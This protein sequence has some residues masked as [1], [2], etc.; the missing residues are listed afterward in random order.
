LSPDI[1]A[2]PLA[3][4]D[5]GTMD[6]LPALRAEGSAAPARWGRLG[7]TLLLLGLVVWQ[8]CMTLGLFGEERPWERVLDDEPV[9]SGRHPLHLYHGY[10]GAWSL[11]HTGSACCYDPAFQAGYP[12]TPVFDSGS[13]PAEF[14]LALA[15]GT[16]NPAAYKI[17]LAVCCMLVPV[18]LIVA[19]RG[20]GLGLAGTFLATAMGLL[21][22]WGGPGRKAL[23]AGDVDL[24][25][26]AL[27]ALAHA[28]LLLQFCRAASVDCWVGLL[29]TGCL[30]WYSHPLLYFVLSPLFLVYYVTV[31]TRH[32]HLPWHVALLATQA[33][34]LAINSFW[35]V[36]WVTYWWIRSPLR[37][38]PVTLQHRTL[39]T[40]WDAPVWGGPAD[41]ALAVVIL[42]SALLG[43]VLFH[44]GRQRAAARV[45]G[46]GAWG[47]WLLAVLGV[48]WE[49][50]GRVGTHGL[51]VPALWF[52]AVPAAHAWVQVYRALGY[53][54]GS[55]LRA[56]VLAA[57]LLAGLGMALRDEVLTFVDR[58]SAT[59]PLVIGL[60]PER[61]ALKD[62]LL[63]YTTPDAR[64]L[65]EDRPTSRETPQWSVLLPHLTGRSFIG[66]LD[67]EAD[68]EYT[69]LGLADHSLAGQPIDTWSAADL[70]AYCRRYNVGWVVCWSPAAVTRFRTWPAA[71]EIAPVSDQGTGYLFAVGGQPHSF[72]RKGQARL[73]HADCHHITFADVVPEAGKV[74]LS[75]HYQTG[76]R[77][78]PGR[79]QIEREE[80]ATDS[81]PF[82]RLNIS[83]GPVA[84]VTLTWEDR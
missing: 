11:W 35:L 12:K 59:T 13:R 46:L 21:V 81:I 68:I 67:A 41:R 31:G 7:W 62:S 84:R 33:G 32:R 82:I 8:A 61:A 53:L 70:D 25:L 71:R 1:A 14:F 66:G 45:L 30:G 75:L 83:G 3:D 60:G 34:A 17:G 42:G 51:M 15:G 54:S 4:Y 58:C 40:I 19:A 36:D 57:V 16:Y 5:P 9:L 79:V 22:W 20:A 10:L 28:G 55:A 38:S 50:L 6:R 48:S 69:S 2:I 52:A 24:Y 76:M 23:E 47:L 44:F 63:N 80:D 43:V 78:T 18:L 56:A 74:L 29:L 73:V 64:I 27:A 37:H 77:A 72:A 39:H 49:P 65:W 26:A